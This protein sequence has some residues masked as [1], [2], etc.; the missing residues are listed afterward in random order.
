VVGAWWVRRPASISCCCVMKFRRVTYAQKK[1]LGHTH[2]VGPTLVS[3]SQSRVLVP[4]QPNKRMNRRIS[5]GRNGGAEGTTALAVTYWIELS[6]S[7]QKYHTGTDGW[8]ADSLYFA[9]SYPLFLR[10]SCTVTGVQL[11]HRG[12]GE[13]REASREQVWKGQ[14]GRACVYVC[15]NVCACVGTGT[16]TGIII[17]CL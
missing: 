15:V 16:G 1:V 14:F 8:T 9:E 11:V 7:R 2:Q 4:T 12:D 17:V 5:L 6:K 3:G 13:L 10:L